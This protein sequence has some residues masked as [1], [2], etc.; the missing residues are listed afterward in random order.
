MLSMEQNDALTVLLTGRAETNFAEIIKRITSS[1]KLEFDLIC[2]KPQAGPNNQIFVSTMKY[3]QAL[4]KDLVY[5][6]K[7]A[8]EIRIY[9][10]RPGQYVILFDLTLTYHSPAHQNLAPNLFENSLTVSTGRFYPRPRRLHAKISPRK[11]FK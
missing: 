3:K 2:L 10:D 8:D 7:D 1:K 11:L 5:T 4:L 9:E 6:Y